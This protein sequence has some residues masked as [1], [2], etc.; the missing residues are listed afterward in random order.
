MLFWIFYVT[1]VNIIFMMRKKRS[2]FVICLLM[3][4][5]LQKYF[6][7]EAKPAGIFSL[8]WANTILCAGRIDL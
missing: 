1:A 4:T 3:R 5:I 6:R 2:I 7:I 8:I